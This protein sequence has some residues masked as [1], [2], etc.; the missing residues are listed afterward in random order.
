MQLVK[1]CTNCGYRGPQG[2]GEVYYCGW[3]WDS[4]NSLPAKPRKVLS[5]EQVQKAKKKARDINAALKV[6][7]AEGKAAPK[8]LKKKAKAAA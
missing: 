3:C 4:W 8:K 5:P 1:T 2:W 7:K 6:Y